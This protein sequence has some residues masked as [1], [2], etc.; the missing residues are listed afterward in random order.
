MYEINKE[1][2]FSTAHI[3]EAESTYLEKDAGNENVICAYDNGW[4]WRV[5]CPFNDK[6][7]FSQT[8]SHL[9]KRGLVNIAAMLEL[10][11]A[12]ECK[13]LV[14]DCDGPVVESLPQF[15]W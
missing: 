12:N 6:E 5:L 4:S 15:E 3:T 8:L 13:W 2:V 10:A 7:E 14:I 9:R 11:A 1:I